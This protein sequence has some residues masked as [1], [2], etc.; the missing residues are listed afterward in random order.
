MAIIPRNRPLWGSNQQ[1]GD[2]EEQAWRTYLARRN[3][4]QLGGGTGGIGSGATG[5]GAIGTAQTGRSP[6]VSAADAARSGASMAYQPMTSQGPIGA[7]GQQAGGQ[8][9]QAAGSPTGSSGYTPTGSGTGTSGGNLGGSSQ[10]ADPG[11]FFS[12]VVEAQLGQL[13]ADP[14]LAAR[15]WAKHRGGGRASENILG[16]WTDPNALLLGMGYSNA[17][18]GESEDYLKK[19]QALWDQAMGVGSGPNKY[20]DLGQII[21]NVLASAGRLTPGQGPGPNSQA[22]DTAM[23]NADARVQAENITNELLAVMNAQLTPTAFT[24]Y[25]NILNDLKAEYLDAWMTDPTTAQQT[26]GNYGRFLQ[27]RLGPGLGLT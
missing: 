13:V 25:E 3:A 21:T 4:S 5:A 8:V 17:A 22:I 14:A 18:L 7:T 19:Q 12:P 11:Y 23:Y 16:Q 10:Y 6:R 9:F 26:M 15:W 1:V 24:A 2:E 27:S 20:V